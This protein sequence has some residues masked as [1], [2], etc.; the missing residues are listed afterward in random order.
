M[1]YSLYD[2]SF[3]FVPR[4]NSFVPVTYSRDY[5]RLM[6]V[7]NGDVLE[8]KSTP[9]E[10]GEI[11]PATAEA[12][13]IKNGE[14]YE[15]YQ[16]LNWMKHYLFNH[17]AEEWF[18]LMFVARNYAPSFDEDRRVFRDCQVSKFTVKSLV[19]ELNEGRKEYKKFS[20]TKEEQEA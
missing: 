16:T 3:I 15:W 6:R 11:A 19:R 10:F 17:E 13:G 5:K 14:G 2:I 8:L 12:F 1:K 7:D 20:Y 4:E 18:T 9:K